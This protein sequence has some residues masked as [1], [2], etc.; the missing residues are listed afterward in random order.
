MPAE[1]MTWEEFCREHYNSYP[2]YIR[3]KLV[4]TDKKKEFRKK[5]IGY[6]EESRNDREDRIPK[7]SALQAMEELHERF[8][9]DSMKIINFT[10]RNR[11]DIERDL[12]GDDYRNK[13]SRKEFNLEVRG[14]L[15][16]IREWK[17]QE[18]NPMAR[19][20]LERLIQGKQE[21]YSKPEYMITAIV[22]RV[23][24]LRKG[25]KK[26]PGNLKLSDGMLEAALRLLD[27]DSLGEGEEHMVV[28]NEH[29]GLLIEMQKHLNNTRK[30]NPRSLEDDELEEFTSRL[31]GLT[32]GEYRKN[33]GIVVYYWWALRI[34]YT[35]A[36]SNFEFKESKL[37]LDRMNAEKENME[38]EVRDYIDCI[39]SAEDG[40]AREKEIQE[41]H[42][43]LAE[44]IFCPKP[45]LT[46][47]RGSL[48][49]MEGLLYR[50][51]L[52]DAEASGNAK[53]FSWLQTT[54]PVKLFAR[55]RKSIADAKAC[56]SRISYGDSNAAQAMLM[57]VS[58]DLLIRIR[59][60]LSGSNIYNAEP[61]DW[62][63]GRK[64]DD[65]KK[66]EIELAE[67]FRD[68]IVNALE[69]VR[70]LSLELGTMQELIGNWIEALK[71]IEFKSP[72]E[73]YDTD[74]GGTGQRGPLGQLCDFC[75]KMVGWGW[76]R[77][78]KKDPKI[79][80]ENDD[81]RLHLFDITGDKPEVQTDAFLIISTQGGNNNPYLRQ[82]G[83]SSSHQ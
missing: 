58:I 73:K 22:H 44:F 59:W 28:G 48:R 25:L 13:K 30:S 42:R 16:V 26:N 20:S 83:E 8:P 12:E 62:G 31:E 61:A 40:E 76:I 6:W 33:P 56:I 71:K 19:D 52:G 1:M 46:G 66:S 67:E 69:G 27:S 50:V 54:Q 34:S 65:S 41:Y 74:K 2:V 38:E 49:K 77:V 81:L 43:A 11:R 10:N 21:L 60:F 4:T 57:L 18:K 35:R 5:L 64:D 9:E 23:R 14:L 55:C 47:T 45:A 3:R 36:R 53:L 32:K 24:R 63:T 7:P 51:A 29:I 79:W 82:V 39:E 78:T 68:G 80:D 70:S 72:K 17:G 37:L 15:S 75:G